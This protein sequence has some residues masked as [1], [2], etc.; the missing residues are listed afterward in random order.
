MIHVAPTPSANPVEALALSERFVLWNFRAWACCCRGQRLPAE[1][2]V[3]SLSRVGAPEA[4]AALDTAMTRL[5]L[6][7]ARP[8][9]VSCPPHPG[10]SGDE[11]RLLAA[12]AAAQR[13]DR[14]ELARLF[15]DILPDPACAAVGHALMELAGALAMVGILLPQPGPEA[16]VAVTEGWAAQTSM[17]V[18]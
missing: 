6:E 5:V 15:A 1:P 7:A 2:V 18:H 12:T 4:A 3:S 13:H 17:T 16:L 9:A 10:L 14:G 11:R 8:L